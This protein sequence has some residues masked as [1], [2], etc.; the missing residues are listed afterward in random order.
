VATARLA[1]DRTGRIV[2][3]HVDFVLNVGGQTV[4]YVPLS[5]MARV[6]PSVYDIPAAYVR[7]RGVFTHTVPT[8]PYRGAGR[9]EAMFIIERLLDLAADRTGIDRIELRRRNLIS[10]DRLPYRSAVGLAY[11]SGDFARNMDRA[12]ALADWSG[13]PARWQAAERRGRL[14]GIG[15]ANYVE[16]PVGAPHERVRLTRQ[17]DGCVEVVVGTQ[18]TGQGHETAFAQVVADQ[19]GISAKQVRIVS[20]DTD[21]VAAGG[22]THSDRSLRLVATLLI[23]ACAKLAPGVSVAEAS[24]TGRLPAYPTGCAVCELE[25]DPE[26]GALDI[27]R[28]SCVDDVG[29]AINPLIVHGQVHGGIA[30]GLGQ[31][32]WERGDPLAASFLD[33]A[34]PRA[35]R[36][37]MFVSELSEDP[38]YSNPLRIKGGGESGITPSLAAVVNAAVDALRAHG[39]HDL[40]MPLTSA[41]IWEALNSV[42]SR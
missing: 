37:P 28:Y 15:M 24:F 14:A 38:T 25:I 1:L 3:L 18:A 9:P 40:H 26:T 16:S 17:P 31:A 10:R 5:N 39:V 33:Y 30:Q 21:T 34:I 19:L 11:D 8:G 23:E 41:S 13:F 32:L 36:L 20:G 35:S 12:L 22:G 27:T 4:S 7:V 6:L 29:Q 2:A 42:S